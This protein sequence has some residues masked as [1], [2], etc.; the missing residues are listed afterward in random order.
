MSDDGTGDP[1]DTDPRAGGRSARRTVTLSLPTGNGLVRLVGALLVVVLVA[2]VVVEAVR[3]HDLSHDKSRLSQQL[4]DLSGVAPTT[5]ASS[6]AGLSTLQQSALAAARTYAT[7]FATYNYK[8]FNAQLAL[9]ESHSID[10]FLT[11]YRTEAAPLRADIVKVKSVS[12]GKVISA[13]VASISPTTA[14]VDLFLNQTISNSAS[15]TPRVE[16]QRVEM[17]L[18]RR[19]SQWLISKVLLP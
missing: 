3:L 12:T 10:P 6:A 19:G 2:I 18:T 11:Q 7:E 4:K 8:D 17:T 9:T 16:S 5:S 1:P 14:V 15:S 13:G